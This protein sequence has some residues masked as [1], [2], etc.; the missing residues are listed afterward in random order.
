MMFSKMH[1]DEEISR[2]RWGGQLKLKFNH[3]YMYSIC[4]IRR[5]D[6]QRDEYIYY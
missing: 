1:E 5:I 4:L 6:N 3:M 2:G